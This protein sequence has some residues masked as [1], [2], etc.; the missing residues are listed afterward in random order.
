[1]ET[2]HRRGTSS[3]MGLRASAQSSHP[4][5][6]VTSNQPLPRLLD[7]CIEMRGKTSPKSAELTACRGPFPSHIA[8]G[9]QRTSVW[10]HRDCLLVVG[11]V[12]A[13]SRS[14]WDESR[15][16]RSFY[17]LRGRNPGQ[18]GALQRRHSCA[19][20]KQ[21]P[22]HT[23]PPPKSTRIVRRQDCA[24]D[25]VMRALAG[26]G[27]G[28]LPAPPASISRQAIRSGKPLEADGGR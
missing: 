7:W 24:E 27:G 22:H 18:E 20:C 19:V 4:R 21:L 14:T 13:L 15:A 10:L 6:P 8:F 11:C 25:A 28:Y 1:L 3:P 26:P 12:S 16:G 17:F 23:L 5:S 2:P 9:L